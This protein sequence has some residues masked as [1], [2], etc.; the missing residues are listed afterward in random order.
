M[1]DDDKLDREWIVRNVL[2][3]MSAGFGLRGRYLLAPFCSFFSV[4]FRF[5]LAD[6]SFPLLV[7]LDIYPLFTTFIILVGWLAKTVVATLLSSWVGGDENTGE[8]WLAYSIP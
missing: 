8:A 5:S 3:G 4:S 7:I 6:S 2:G 1:L